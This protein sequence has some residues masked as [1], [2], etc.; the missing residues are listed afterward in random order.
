MNHLHSHEW[1]PPRSS[2]MNHD[3]LS[4]D[5]MWLLHLYRHK[6]EVG[7]WNHLASMSS[8]K[9]RDA[10][11]NEGKRL[12]SFQHIS[13]SSGFQETKEVPRKLGRKKIGRKT[14]T[15]YLL[16]AFRHRM[17]T[18]AFLVRLN[19]RSLLFLSNPACTMA[20]DLSHGMKLLG[21][22]NSHETHPVTLTIL[23]K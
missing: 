22:A 9:I 5:L 8:C 12:P 19:M 4:W 2:N 16:F 21:S 13:T 20:R 15:L 17:S 3:S 11:K 23:T 6:L 18:F 10:R 7:I 14:Y 1:W